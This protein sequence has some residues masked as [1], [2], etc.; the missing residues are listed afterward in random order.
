MS[1]EQERID[2]ENER[3]FGNGQYRKKEKT[4]RLGMT[5]QEVIDSGSG[6][7]SKHRVPKWF[8]AVLIVL[9]LIAYAL[10]LPFWGDRVDNPRPWLTWGH[11]AALLYM[12]VFGGFVYL[13]TTRYNRASNKAE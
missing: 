8:L 11:L 3:L 2:E 12:L 5:D 4:E 6:L 9:V 7:E 13:M 1:V 10:N